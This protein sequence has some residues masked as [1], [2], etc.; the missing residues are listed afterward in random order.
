MIGE[1]Q[2][3]KDLMDNGQYMPLWKFS[4]ISEGYYTIISTIKELALKN[5]CLK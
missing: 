3:A 2:K 1:L 5:N 4:R